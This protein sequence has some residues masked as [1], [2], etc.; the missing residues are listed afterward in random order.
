MSR[1]CCFALVGMSGAGKSYWAQRV[2]PLGYVHHD[3]DAAIASRLAE[4]VEPAPAE[5]PV[6]AL[7]RWMGA[8]WTPGYT[9]R[10]AAYLQLEE[11]VTRA[12]LEALEAQP[13]TPQLVDL[14]GS[15]VYLP[16]PLLARLREQARVVY[17]EVGAAHREAM[18]QRY[19]A[20]PKPV[21]WG[22]GW[23]PRP[24]AAPLDE[25]PRLYAALLEHRHERYQSLADVT[26]DAAALERHPPSAE[27][28]V[29]LVFDL[30][31]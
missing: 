26:L 23:Q 11:Q 7:G 25:L 17:L 13:H 16:A 2:A 21:V 8:P 27:Q 6:A 10:Q 14:T 22:E 30:G 12:A 1:T 5:A 18:L 3:C 15:A 28:F 20:Q 9:E 19:L 29:R 4:L 24:G 31:C